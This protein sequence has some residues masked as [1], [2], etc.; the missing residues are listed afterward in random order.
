MKSVSVIIPTYNYG[1]FIANAIESCIDQT[2]PKVEIIVIDDGSTDDTRSIVDRFGDRVVYH[3]QINQGV[4]SARN[5]G[6]DRAAGDFV[7]FLDADDYFVPDAIEAMVDALSSRKNVGMVIGRSYSKAES[8]SEM[9]LHNGWNRNRAVKRPYRD[10]LL[11]RLSV[12]SPLLRGEL[13]RRFRFPT[14]ITNGEDIAYYAKILY[15]SDAYLLAR[16]VLVI[17]RHPDC[18]HKN[19][20]RIEI[21]GDDLIKAVFDD[22]F[23]NQDI[24]QLRSEVSALFY[25]SLFRSFYIAGRGKESRK[26]Y[27]QALK[28]RPL[29]VGRISYLSKFLKTLLL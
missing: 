5:A 23:Y 7:C 6:L 29:I 19:I 27:L 28:A 14:G 25:L 15:L 26:Y 9:R 8:S 16:P 18:L 12:T 20:G 13:A 3:Y 24:E 4:S 10:V 11:G 17:V 2:H 1:R 21:Q 22:P